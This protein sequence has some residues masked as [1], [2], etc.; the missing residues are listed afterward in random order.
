MQVAT[1]LKAKGVS[2]DLGRISG[3]AAGHDIGKYGCKGEELKR[4]PYLHY[5]YSDVWFNR[6]GINYIRN[7]AINHSTWD[8]E[9][10]NLPLESLILI[11]SD[12]RVKNKLVDHKVAMHIH[13]LKEAFDV[14]LNKLDNVDEAKEKRYKRV[15]GKLLDFEDFMHSLGVN[16]EI[17]ICD[18]LP[19]NANY[20]NVISDENSLIYGYDN[21]NYYSLM[22]GSKV[23]DSLKYISIYHNINLMYRLR[24]EASLYEILESARGEKDW[25]NLREYIRVF[26]EYSTYLTQIQKLQTLNFLFENLIHPE[27]DIRRHCAEIIGNLIAIFDED[28]RKELPKN[29]V[30]TSNEKNSVEL[31]KE[32]LNLLLYPSHK[33]VANHKSWL[34]Y[35]VSIMVN[36][37]FL[38]SRKN[39][40][41]SYTK[42]LMDF[43]LKTDNRPVEHHLFLLETAKAI[44]LD[45]NNDELS[46]LFEYIFSMLYKRNATVRLAALQVIFSIINR[47]ISTQPQHELMARAE[48]YLINNYNSSG[49]IAEIFVKLKIAKLLKLDAIIPQLEKLCIL[50]NDTLSNIFLSNLKTATDWIKKKSQIELLLEYSKKNDNVLHTCIHFCNLLKVSAVETVRSKAGSAI[51]KLMPLL[52]LSERNEV[53]VELLRALEIEGHRFTEY[54]PRYIG[55]ILLWL[56]PKELDEILDDLIFK[57]KGANPHI[58]PLILKTVGVTLAEYNNYIDRFNEP[59]DFINKRRSKMLGILLNALGDYNSQVKQAAFSVIGKDIFGSSSL[60]LEQKQNIYN[61]IAKKFLTLITDNPSEELL[62]LTSSA[63]LNHVYRFISDYSFFKGELQVKTSEKV[64]FFPGT[65]DPFSLSHKEIAKSIRNMGFDVYLAIDEFSWSKQTLPNTLRKNILNMSVA[66]E[67]G[68]YIYPSNIPTN[69]TNSN[70]LRRLKNNFKNSQ[71]Y[72]VAGSDVILNAS[73]YKKPPEESYILSFPHIIFERNKNKELENLCK[74]IAGEVIWLSLQPKFY[75]ISSTQIRQY[76][77][78][79]KEISSLVDPL[80]QQYIYENG[81]YQR[82]PQNK[83]SLKSLWLDIE[84]VENFTDDIISEVSSCLLGKSLE[85]MK[86]LKELSLKDSGRLVVLRDSSN[87]KKIIGFSAFHWVR[88]SSLYQEL[89]HLPAAE[90]VR[91]KSIGRIILIDGFY[92]SNDDKYIAQCLITETLAFCISKD[93]EFAVFKN[94][95]K[96]LSS[97]AILDLLRLQGFN[98]IDCEGSNLMVVNMSTPSVLNLDIENTLKE[99][100]RSHPKVINVINETRRKLQKALIELYPGQLILSFETNVLHQCMIKK[101]CNENNVPT[102]P[103]AVGSAADLTLAKPYSE[104]NFKATIPQKLLGD[105]MCV[106][107]GDILDRYV[108]PNTVTK[109]LHT[110]KLFEPDMQSFKIAEFPHYLELQSQV[111]TL[112]SFNRQV[113][114]VDNILHKGY[115]MKALDPLFKQED[116]KVK[117]I[118]AGILSGR[119]K[120]LMDMQ[121][122]E[123]DSVYFIPRLKI[124]FNENSLYPFIGGDALWRGLYPER[125]CYLL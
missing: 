55:N 13:S 105:F 48:A 15:Y 94:M 69:I 103:I 24:D 49:N 43:Y 51:L 81:F 112:K 1:Q 110:E 122:R 98:S 5:Y 84:V 120:D 87:N 93:Y 47:L 73:A 76:I 114:L 30:L 29:V 61:I 72:M 12:F 106:P 26:E 79:N 118:I 54:I 65:F 33:F 102:K 89:R 7:I 70:D 9:L 125:N 99:P 8:L 104:G 10:E 56:Q 90:Y 11:Y 6:L 117:K 25:K 64:A 18:T 46:P 17:D 41:K 80:A 68:I 116:I 121:N 113:I 34:G 96:E 22:H 19:T 39:L 3:A 67:L 91:S 82:E 109:A 115:R 2:L 28:Y 57:I 63:S 44:P 42:V 59:I 37:L 14:I 75:N 86:A 35:S 83:T 97:L 107:Y 40:V 108:I 119:G 100:F 20:K 124:W 71:V 74:N 60:S 78:E 21:K 27:D 92:V 58:K 101:I 111:K 36:S 38:N 123:V 77:D 85:L 23:T 50:D 66:D 95:M 62:F 53:A 31:L 16:T 52:S 4:V 88:S 45:P 32:Y